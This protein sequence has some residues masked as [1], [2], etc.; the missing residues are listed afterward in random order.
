MV[1]RAE[2]ERG[3]KLM[4]EGAKSVEEAVRAQETTP[5]DFKVP[6]FIA[7]LLADAASTA[8]SNRAKL[9]GLSAN[10]SDPEDVRI[11]FANWLKLSDESILSKGQ[12]GLLGDELVDM[13][14]RIQ[15]TW[16]ES[17]RSDRRWV[18]ATRELVVALR[19]RYP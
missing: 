2:I 19:R 5:I 15:K 8:T 9:Q 18:M 6:R 4:E 17:L 3:I 13:V 11:A 7:S 14:N 16:D 10:P 12:L 1:D